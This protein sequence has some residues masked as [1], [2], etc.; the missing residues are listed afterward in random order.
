MKAAFFN[1]TF[2]MGQAANGWPT[3]RTQY[4]D[5]RARY[6]LQEA[7]D[8]FELADQAGFDWV[9][10]AEHHYGPVGLTPNPMVMAAAMAQ[11]VKRA[12]IAILGSNIPM[13]NP[14]RIAEEYAMLDTLTQGRV[15]AGLIRGTPNE[16]V[17]YN[18]NPAESRARFEE[19]LLLIKH[20]W[21]EPQP[22]GWQGRYFQY[23]SICIWPRP[24]QQ[25]HPQ[26]FMSGSSPESAAFAAEAKV[27][28]GIAVSTVQL[29]KAS[30]G[31]YRTRAEELGWT[32]SK[33]DCLYRLSFHVAESDEQA[34]KDVEES[35]NHPQRLSPIMM[36]R[37]L[38]R[39]VAGTGYYGSDVTKQSARNTRSAG[40]N[41]RIDSGQLIIGSPDTVVHQ[42]ER[43]GEELG[44]G[45]LDLVPAFQIGQPTRRS[46][47]L[48]GR[49]VLP[50][51]R[52]V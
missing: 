22:F 5:E 31:I 15:V 6:S 4:S 13:L 7:L 28:L 49:E 30:F 16:Y 2:Y 39:T 46:I 34:L 32:P 38:E 35:H 21:T 17:T 51:V 23:R 43:I 52:N 48:F 8:Q 37:A 50:R 20:I 1:S 3:P 14:I 40:L 26:I 29:A 41:D 27:S 24:V 18:V 10:L 19:A 11:V 33:D 47:E 25:P 12:K 9:T 44:V 42:I 45:V 36:N